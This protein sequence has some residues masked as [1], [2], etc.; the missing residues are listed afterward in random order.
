MLCIKYYPIP[1]TL[2]ALFLSNFCFGQ[3][4][5]P[6][7]P[8]I[9]F[10]RFRQLSFLPPAPEILAVLK[11]P[12]LDGEKYGLADADGKIL[13]EPQFEEIT[14]MEWDLPVFLAKKY[15]KWAFFDLNGRQTLPFSSANQWELAVGYE[16]KGFRFDERGNHIELLI[17]KIKDPRPATFTDPSG[18]SKAASRY[19]FLKSGTKPP[20]RAWFM[21]DHLF[22]IQ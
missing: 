13:L 12:F 11:I 5:R 19:Y 1:F 10:E 8:P 9:P 6:A 18:K 21:P 16:R 7:D 20:F 14:W 2:L 4:N 17:P 15:G 3:N 22:F